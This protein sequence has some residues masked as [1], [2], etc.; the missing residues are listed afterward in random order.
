MM[1]AAGAGL[2]ARLGS[3]VFAVIG[4]VF[5]CRGAGRSIDPAPRFHGDRRRAVGP[6]GGSLN[7][8]EEP[9]AQRLLPSTKLTVFEFPLDEQR[10][11]TAGR[12]G[13]QVR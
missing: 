11:E 3:G 2:L 7:P 6:P 9:R 4:T 8:L 12:F 10:A 5:P 13:S 1:V